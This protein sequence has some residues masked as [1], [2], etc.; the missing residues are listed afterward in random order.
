MKVCIDAGH[1]GTYP[2]A[3]G[4]EPY[5]YKEKE[6]NLSL[7]LL[8]EKELEW[9]GHWVVMTR[10]KDRTLGL[11]T[12]PKFANRL[13][14]DLFVSIHA[15]GAGIPSVEGH[16]DLVLPRLYKRARGCRQHS[17]RGESHLP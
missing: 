8:L 9:R 11:Y 15:N 13:G 12:R 4:K 1:G 3:V 5:L 7:A 10:R 2:G 6:F 16:G 14:A 17:R